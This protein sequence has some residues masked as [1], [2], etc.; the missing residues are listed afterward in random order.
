MVGSFVDSV[1]LL[2]EEWIAGWS[3]KLL[4][5]TAVARVAGSCSQLFA[6]RRVRLNSANAGTCCTSTPGGRCGCNVVKESG[7]RR[8]NLHMLCQSTC[9]RFHSVDRQ[10]AQGEAKN[11]IAV[12]MG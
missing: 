5:S 12:E 8:M 3:F 4:Y 9:D 10:W 6:Y 11:R 1:G 2:M 7:K